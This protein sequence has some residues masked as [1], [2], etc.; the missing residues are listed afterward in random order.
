MKKTLIAASLGLAFFLPQAEASFYN[1]SYTF[2]ANTLA[3]TIEGNLQADN[4]TVAIN[5]IQDPTLNG[6]AVPSL[7]FTY[8]ADNFYSI[9]FP[10]FYPIQP[11]FPN[12]TTPWV[13]LDGSYMNLAAFNSSN[14]GNGIDFSAGSSLAQI[15]GE[16]T[17]FS[18]ASYGAVHIAFNQADW[19]MSAVPLPAA[20]WLFGAG[21][22]GWLKTQKRKM[23]A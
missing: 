6:A 8:N 5:S 11:G 18:G 19:H 20:V 17:F 14:G 13:S 12:E 2:G 4:K 7:A 10:S 23:A 1:F 3:G 22:L 21:L 16:P 15:L 9:K